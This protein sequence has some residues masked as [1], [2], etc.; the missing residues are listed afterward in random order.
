MIQKFSS[1]SLPFEPSC[2][3]WKKKG[4]YWNKRNANIT[5]AHC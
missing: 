2:E 5:D 3:N 4:V 1:V